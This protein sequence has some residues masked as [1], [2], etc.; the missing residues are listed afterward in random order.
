MESAAILEMQNAAPEK[1]KTE[2]SQGQ[3]SMDDW[4]DEAATV[5]DSF[6]QELSNV[7]GNYIEAVESDWNVGLIVIKQSRTER[8]L[9]LATVG[10]KDF[11]KR[12][13]TSKSNGTPVEASLYI[14]KD[15]FVASLTRDCRSAAKS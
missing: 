12:Q 14:E 5:T 13:I 6:I 11:C 3:L 15:K 1:R 7:G 4:F 8:P 10:A 2:V 9:G